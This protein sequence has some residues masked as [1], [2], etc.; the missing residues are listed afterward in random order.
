VLLVHLLNERRETSLECDQTQTIRISLYIFTTSLGNKMYRNMRSSDQAR[1][2]YAAWIVH[3]LFPRFARVFSPSRRYVVWRQWRSRHEYSLVPPSRR[4][5]RI[6]RIWMVA[7]IVCVCIVPHEI[8][9]A[10]T[11]DK[12][13]RSAAEPFRKAM[14]VPEKDLPRDLPDKAECVVIVPGFKKSAFLVGGKYG[15]GFVSCRR[16]SE[17]WGPP[18]GVEI[19][20]GSYGFQIGG[21]SSDVFMLIMNENGTKRRSEPKQRPQLVRL[22][23]TS[24]P[25]QTCRNARRFYPGR[26]LVDSPIK[27]KALWDT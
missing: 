2:M 6:W 19:E 11:P 17:R 9:R 10:E 4:M 13:L 22:R 1:R 12:R 15:R 18:A 16:R 26:A 24:A 21:S 8:L 14:K 7:V 5:V 20:G 25:I 3:R 27:M 23:E